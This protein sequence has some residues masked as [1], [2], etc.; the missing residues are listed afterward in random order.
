MKDDNLHESCFI[1]RK[2]TFIRILFQIHLS[3]MAPEPACFAV[4]GATPVYGFYQGFV[5]FFGG[6]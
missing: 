5:G 1:S 3:F 6:T 4:L 2:T